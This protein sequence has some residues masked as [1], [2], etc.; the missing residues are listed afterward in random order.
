M[1]S[2]EINTLLTFNLITSFLHLYPHLH[3]D[4]TPLSYFL[5]SHPPSPIACRLPSVSS[6]N[7]FIH[8]SWSLLDSTERER[9]ALR[10]ICL[11]Y[12][13]ATSLS[14]SL[15]LSYRSASPSLPPSLPPCIHHSS[16]WGPVPQRVLAPHLLLL[17]LLHYQPQLPPS[18]RPSLISSLSPL[19]NSIYRS[20]CTLPTVCLFL[21]PISCGFLHCTLIHYTFGLGLG[22]GKSLYQNNYVFRESRPRSGVANVLLSPAICLCRSFIH[23]SSNGHKVC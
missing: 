17:L 20:P 2:N 4:S 18:L 19:P 6:I 13:L 5:A 21:L 14:L 9:V 1:L 12:W 22:A 7:P 10:T 8:L 11:P 16:W 3:L 15:S 23:K